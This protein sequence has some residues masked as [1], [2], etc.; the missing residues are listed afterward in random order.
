MSQ[1]PNI[2]KSGDYDFQLLK[3]ILGGIFII[4]RTS[5]KYN[6]HIYYDI[7]DI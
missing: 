3:E 6:W 1:F 4:Q 2:C 7:H 5:I